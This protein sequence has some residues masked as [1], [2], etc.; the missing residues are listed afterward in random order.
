MPNVSAQGWV[1]S[2]GR[3][4][5]Q[6]DIP[7]ELPLDL[8]TQLEPRCQRAAPGALPVGPGGPSW[9]SPP[10]GQRNGARDFPLSAAQSI[11]LRAAEQR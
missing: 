4:D 9:V 10:Q 11:I 1:K 6:G 5:L 2:M 8:Q 3:R 7:A